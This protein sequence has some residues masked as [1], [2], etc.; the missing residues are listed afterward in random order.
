MDETIG[1]FV[2]S[3]K[4]WIVIGVALLVAG[5][6]WVY[7]ICRD[8]DKETKSS[9]LAALQVSFVQQYGGEAKIEQLVSPSKVYASLWT[10]KEGISHVSWNIGGLW[11]TVWTSPE[12]TTP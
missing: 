10:D 8:N 7:N 1:G 4:A 3:R 11:V 2:K 6:G 9:E 12:N 5:S